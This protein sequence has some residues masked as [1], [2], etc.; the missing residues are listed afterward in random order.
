[1]MITSLPWT[2]YIVLVEIRINQNTRR[3][4]T[5]GLWENK[6][7]MIAESLRLS[8]REKALPIARPVPLT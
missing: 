7:K 8:P 6:N 5:L 4:F 2:S 3:H 1:M